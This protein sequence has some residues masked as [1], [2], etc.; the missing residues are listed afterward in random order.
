M[1]KSNYAGKSSPSM[2]SI[3][4]LLGLLMAI[5][6]Q[7]AAQLGVCY[8]M[9]GD[10]LPPPTEVIAL[11]QQYNIRRMRL[12][13]QNQAAQDALRGT[14]I[15]LMLGVPDEELQ[16]IASA[17]ANA[18]DW[19]RNNVQNYGDVNFKYIAVG[20]EIEP[21]GPYAQ[22]LF[23]AMQNI[24]TAISNAGLGSQIKVS[25]PTFGKAL[26]ESSPPSNGSFSN[27]GYRQLL[28]PVISFLVNSNSPLLVNMYPYFSYIHDTR[29]IHLEYALFT[30]PG[31]VVQD[32]QLGYRNLFDAILDAYYSALEKAGGGSLE[33][34][35]S[36][37]GWP[38]AGETGASTDNARTYNTNLAEHVK[39]GTPKKPG[40][41]IE[42]YVFAMF[43]ENQKNP[44][45]EKHW[46]LF[47]PNKTP[48]YS[49][50]FN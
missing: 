47:F 45:L 11:Y 12:Y 7:T 5:L 40:K 20:N 32:G 35:V 19:I 13:G 2:I 24:Q 49:I 3:M 39:G 43:D 23:P 41:P 34:V 15:E 22:F 8:G 48:K 46:G 6:G 26:G 25:T 1:A 31:V 10:N 16:H 27:D 4:L 44:E 21:Q 50:H 33:I 17:Q 42:T 14:N 18:D 36:E 28:D 29:N 37:T 9:L 30:S 38:S